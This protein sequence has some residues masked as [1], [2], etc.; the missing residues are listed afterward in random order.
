MEVTIACDIMIDLEGS[1]RP[2]VFL[3]EELVRRGH[4]VSMISPLISSSVEQHLQMKQIGAL[5]LEAK[6]ATARLGPSISWFEAWVRE[7]FLKLNTRRI[8]GDFSVT[9]NFS[10]VMS[11][12]STVWYLQG[13]PSIALRDM[14]GELNGCFR[15]AYDLAKA[16]IDHADQKL[17]SRIGRCSSRI[18]ANSIFCAA[19][20][21]SFGIRADEVIY[22]PVDCRIF[23]P[24]AS[25][26][27]SDYVLTYVGKET[28]ISVLQSIANRGVKMKVFGSRIPFFVSPMQRDLA[29]NPNVE[30]R[31][32]VCTDELVDL[33]SN[34]SFTVFPFNHEPFGYVPIESMACG[35]PVLTYDV[36]GPSECVS[37]NQAGWLVHT[38]EEMV[39]RA[40]QLWED[41]YDPGIRKNCVWAASGLDRGV[42][43]R[44]W[45]KVLEGL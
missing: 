29:K 19:M 32:R 37:N 21:S 2:A 24:S 30:Y 9:V 39:Q 44:K 31:G 25:R 43:I 18:I 10:Q 33:Y 4:S 22:P 3:A 36:Q 26:P 45:L 20:Y 23:K 8:R 27:S 17:V 34:A 40:V 12:P 28:K 5:N 42:Y 7:A 16:V 35:T 1:I 14:Q 6:F 38:D 13:P 11:L 15:I 41:G